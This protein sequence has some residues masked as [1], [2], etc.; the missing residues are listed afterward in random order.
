[1]RMITQAAN[2]LREINDFVNEHN[3]PKDHIVNIFQSKDGI[4]NL[5]YYE[6]TEE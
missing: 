6:E 2:K 1:M 4:Y 3:I 5:V